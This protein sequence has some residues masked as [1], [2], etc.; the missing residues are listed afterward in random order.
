MF[1]GAF[2]I[3]L[4]VLSEG[5]QYITMLSLITPV[6]GDHRFHFNFYAFGHFPSVLYLGTGWVKDDGVSPLCPL[7]IPGLVVQ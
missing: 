1:G 5:L 4:Y 6:G 2:Y 7:S 3:Y